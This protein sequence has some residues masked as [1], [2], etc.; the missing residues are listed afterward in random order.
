MR[1]T[2][3]NDSEL[4]EL[5]RQIEKLN[6]FS[7]IFESFNVAFKYCDGGIYEFHCPKCGERSIRFS[8]TGMFYRWSCFQCHQDK[9]GN[10][11]ITLI[12]FLSKKKLSKPKIV[13]KI[14]TLIEV[15]VEA[16]REQRE[17]KLA[18]FFKQYGVHQCSK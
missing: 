13:E 14:R 8:S 5:E 9:W 18:A 3:T 1:D 12:A 2:T 4:R 11:L 6:L 10:D 17:K 16:A 7:P 15:A